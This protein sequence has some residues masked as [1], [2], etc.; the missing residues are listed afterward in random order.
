MIHINSEDYR[1]IRS[2]LKI[3]TYKKFESICHVNLYNVDLVFRIV[4]D[5]NE[6]VREWT[7][8][9]PVNITVVFIGAFGKDGTPFET[10]MDPKIIQI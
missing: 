6:V 5:Y 10:D 9:E 4:C 3:S 8:L 2:A 1:R 7:E